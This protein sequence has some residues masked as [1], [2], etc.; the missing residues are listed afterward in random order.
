MSES[1]EP[2][3]TVLGLD[4]DDGI[5]IVEVVGLDEDSPGAHAV[6]DEV[7]LTLDDPEDEAEHSG[8]AG[9]SSP[10]V[11]AADGEG[12]RER[13]LRIQADFENT[14]KRLL[15]ETEEN[16]RPAAAPLIKRILP[17]LDNFERALSTEP[18]AETSAENL[19]RGVELI[20]RQMLDELRKEGLESIDSVGQA[21]DPEIHDAVETARLDEIPAGTVVEELQRGYRLRGRLLRP[22]LVRVNVND[23]GL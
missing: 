22:S 7:E 6:P 9:A 20:F 12:E 18:G 14:K 19:R 4:D 13:L 11:A 23:S 21:F 5:E 3:H 10:A 17:V 1:Q 15:R 8:P 16:R 2:E